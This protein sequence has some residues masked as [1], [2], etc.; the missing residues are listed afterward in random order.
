[1]MKSS[2]LLSF[3]F[4]TIILQ[5]SWCLASGSSNGEKLATLPRPQAEAGTIKDAGLQFPRCTDFSSFWSLRK[6]RCTQTNSNY[7]REPFAADV[8]NAKYSRKLRNV[9]TLQTMNFSHKGGAGGG[10]GGG[11]GV[12]G[13][14]GGGG[15]ALQA[16]TDR[17][18]GGLQRAYIASARYLQEF[19]KVDEM[20]ITDKRGGG[21]GGEGAGGGGASGGNGNGENGNGEQGSGTGE[22]TNGSESV[23]QG[24]KKHNNAPSL[25]YPWISMLLGFG[26]YTIMSFSSFMI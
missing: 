21:G 11:G 16:T 6:V 14:K 13:G 8:P 24:K 3:F 15:S 25:G 5:A 10:G 19:N 20:E 7:G 18:V 22:N 12:G 26:I 2:L 17:V 23:H 1:M 9:V 4:F